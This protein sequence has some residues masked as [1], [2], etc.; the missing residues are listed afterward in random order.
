MG[1]NWPCICKNEYESDSVLTKRLEEFDSV[2]E[3]GSTLGIGQ[4]SEVKQAT[5]KLDANIDNKVAVKCINLS[6]MKSDEKL[7]KRE[8]GIMKK[9]KHANIV[10]LY[11]IYENNEYIYITM[12]LCSGGSLKEKVNL[13]G[14]MTVNEVRNMA[15]KLLSALDYLHLNH[16]CHR[17]IKPENIL[18]TSEQVKIADFGLARLMEGTS[19]FSMVGTPYYLSPEIISGDY[20][21]KCDIWSLGVVLFFALT[22]R[23]PFYGEG[24]EDLFE[25]ISVTE[26][27]WSG[28]ETEEK[29]FLKCLMT[30][31]HKNRPTARQALEHPWVE[32]Q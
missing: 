3:I 23:L 18:F 28:V 4:F 5:S 25:R 12:E 17:D 11:D 19:K 10:E 8:I 9:I 26:I 1:T 24:Y 15:K 7:L 27:D 6:H 31:D 22:K 20:N 32:V 16:I 21:L 14:P 29:E 13:D 30:R 2:Y